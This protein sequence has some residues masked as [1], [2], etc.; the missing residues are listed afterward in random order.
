MNSIVLFVKPEE[1]SPKTWMHTLSYA[2]VNSD[3]Y[4]VE[5]ATSWLS[6]RSC[7]EI[8]DD[9]DVHEEEQVRLLIQC[10]Q[11]YLIEWRGEELLQKFI[12]D[13]PSGKVAVIDNDHGLICAISKVKGRPISKWIREKKMN[14][15]HLVS[16]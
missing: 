10:P 2:I 7:N 16:C 8:F 1:W 5:T 6:I 14:T 9:Y 15:L 12:D 4:V 3:Q 11:P 13:F